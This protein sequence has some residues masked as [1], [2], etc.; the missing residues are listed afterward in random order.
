MAPLQR[1]LVT[2]KSATKVAT[3]EKV[4]TFYMN[5]KFII[6]TAYLYIV[7]IFEDTNIC[8][9]KNTQNVFLLDDKSN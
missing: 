8:W 1:R 5:E 3:H 4:S 2:V 7:L 9:A 6:K